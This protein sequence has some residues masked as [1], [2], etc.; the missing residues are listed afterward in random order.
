[1]C[2]FFSLSLL[3]ASNGTSI[4]ILEKNWFENGLPSE[5]LVYPR[6]RIR[7]CQ[8]FS[9]SLLVASKGTSISILGKTQSGCNFFQCFPKDTSIISNQIKFE[10]DCFENGLPSEK[11]GFFKILGSIVKIFAFPVVKND[12]RANTF[13]EK[14]IIQ[15]GPMV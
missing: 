8:F 5:K 2:Q 6:P 10:K 11:I 13:Q 12:P 9:W 1:M 15:I 4:S 14:K 7:M 3:V